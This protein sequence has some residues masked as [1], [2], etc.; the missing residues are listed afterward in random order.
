[1]LMITRCFFFTLADEY[2]VYDM[3][4]NA[5]DSNGQDSRT[6]KDKKAFR[7]RTLTTGPECFLAPVNKI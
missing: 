7:V 4:R 2:Q 6:V 1:M 3:L 5:L